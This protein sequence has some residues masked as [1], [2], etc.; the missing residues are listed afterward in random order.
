MGFRPEVGEKI[1]L[2]KDVYRFEKHPAVIDKR[3]LA[4]PL[5]H[6]AFQYQLQLE[7]G[8]ERIALKVF[9]ERYREEKH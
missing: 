1:S 8:V 9:K 4:F 3:F 2:N 7:N 6:R 5:G